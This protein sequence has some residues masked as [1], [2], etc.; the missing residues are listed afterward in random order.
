MHSGHADGNVKLWNYKS[1]T[2]ISR[3]GRYEGDQSAIFV[4]DR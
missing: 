3:E 1:A 4:A 2:K